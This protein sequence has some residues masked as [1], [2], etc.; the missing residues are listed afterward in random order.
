MNSFN[1]TKEQ[2]LREIRKARKLASVQLEQYSNPKDK[3]DILQSLVETVISSLSSHYTYTVQ[4]ADI[5]GY[6][7]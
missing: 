7:V 4:Q 5:R 3:E 2:A 6:E 1:D